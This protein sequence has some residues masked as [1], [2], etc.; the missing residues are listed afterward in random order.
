MFSKM[1]YML[2]EVHSILLRQP[3]LTHSFNAKPYRPS[4]LTVLTKK[5][6]PFGS[7]SR[8][9]LLK[10]LNHIKLTSGQAILGLRG[11][12]KYADYPWE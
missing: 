12:G 6:E 3:W 8:A 7:G 4:I 11:L 10:Y 9:P 5:P 1:S 2:N